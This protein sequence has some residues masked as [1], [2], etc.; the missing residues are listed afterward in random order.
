MGSMLSLWEVACFLS[1]STE[2]YSSHLLNAVGEILD[3]VANLINF[4]PKL[5]LF[6]GTTLENESGERLHVQAV[7]FLLDHFTDPVH[8]T[9][10]QKLHQQS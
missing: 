4:V 2:L 1:Y 7:L 9:A 5:K 6:L 3:M 8:S 10:M